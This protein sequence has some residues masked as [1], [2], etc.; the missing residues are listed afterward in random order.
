MLLSLQPIIC[1]TQ[2]TTKGRNFKGT[3]W[4]KWQTLLFQEWP[5]TLLHWIFPHDQ[6]W[7]I[8]VSLFG[9]CQSVN[10]S[11]HL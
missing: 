7:Q 10:I 9:S 1:A 2:M 5:K 11:I 3:I 4:Y 6:N 8:S